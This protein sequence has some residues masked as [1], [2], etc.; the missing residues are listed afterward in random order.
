MCV[1][2]VSV[3]VCVLRAR[4]RAC[5]RARA[6]RRIVRIPFFFSFLKRDSSSS[7]GLLLLKPAKINL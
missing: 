3:Y 7:A 4:V 6:G 2:C 1:A 5:E